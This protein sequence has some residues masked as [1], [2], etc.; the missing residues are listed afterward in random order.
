M[1]D[2]IRTP[3]STVSREWLGRR[4]HLIGGNGPFH[5][6]DKHDKH[7]TGSCWV[8]HVIGFTVCVLLKTTLRGTSDSDSDSD[9][10]SYGRQ[11]GKRK[12]RSGR[13]KRTNQLKLFTFRF[14]SIHSRYSFSILN[15]ATLRTNPPSKNKVEARIPPPYQDTIYDLDE[16][17]TGVIRLRLIQTEIHTRIKGN[18]QDVCQ[19]PHHLL[20]YRVCWLVMS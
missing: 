2:A 17:R 14:V 1:K 20:C 8:W 11:K 5:G 4:R 9:S 6:L 7:F 3:E 15:I 13:R 16:K 12:E 18:E 10:D 19:F